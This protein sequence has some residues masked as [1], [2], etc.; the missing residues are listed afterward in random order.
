MFVEFKNKSI[1]V[2]DEQEGEILIPL[3]ANST[4]GFEFNVNLSLINVTTS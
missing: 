3:K 4:S 2:V 1:M